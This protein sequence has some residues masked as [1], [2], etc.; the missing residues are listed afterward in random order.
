VI[1][2][3]L[4]LSL[5]AAPASWSSLDATARGRLIESLAREPLGERIA[6]TSQRFL[7]TPYVLSPLGEGQGRDKDPLVRFDAVDCLTFVEETLALSLA[8]G[9]DEL[10][11]LLTQIRYAAAPT[12]EG[13]NH[14][15]EAEWIPS[16][17]RKGF[18]RDVTA[19]YGGKDARMSEKVISRAAWKTPMAQALGLEKKEQPTGHFPLTVLPL[20]KLEAHAA[21]IPTGTI[22]VVVRDDSPYRVTRMTHLGFVIQKKGGTF[23]RHASS[24][25]ANRVIDEPLAHFLA[26]NERYPWKVD[27][28]S[29]FEVRSRSAVIAHASP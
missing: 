27:G 6:K 25:P 10:L 14:L 9:G 22:F 29:L 21:G 11:P 3:L 23:L 5:A 1:A 2:P 7:G 8:R 24:A 17:E 15:M 18:V 20:D 19:R 4:A 28:V 16:N 26:R 13:R 12:Y